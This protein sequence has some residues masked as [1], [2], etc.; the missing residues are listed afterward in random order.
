MFL[1]HTKKMAIMWGDGGDNFIVVIIS[2][3][4]HVSDHHV[5]H[6]ELIQCYMLIESQ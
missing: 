1:P 3:Y 2:Q 5:A 4:I 6:L